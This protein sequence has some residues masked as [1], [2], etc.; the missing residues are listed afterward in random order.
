MTTVVEPI[1]YSNRRLTQELTPLFERT[2]YSENTMDSDAERSQHDALEP[3]RQMWKRVL[4][5]VSMV[6]GEIFRYSEPR[7]LIEV[8]SRTNRGRTGSLS[9]NTQILNGRSM[10]N[11]ILW[12]RTE[13][14]SCRQGVR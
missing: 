1:V 11:G 8:L 13:E 10:Q 12:R 9:L 3:A 6:F 2:V 5:V 14:R 4:Y 7:K